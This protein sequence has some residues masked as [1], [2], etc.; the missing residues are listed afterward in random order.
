MGMGTTVRV[1]A[2]QLFVRLGRH[3]RRAGAQH[4]ETGQ[5]AVFALGQLMRDRR[6]KA[7]LVVIGAG[8][9]AARYKLLNALSEEDITYTVYDNVPD[10]PTAADAEAMATAYQSAGCD[11]LIALGDGPLLDAVKA[12]AAG[13]GK[14]GRPVK[15]LAHG[16]V[17]GRRIPPV[18]AA[19]TSSGSGAESLELAAV[20][21]GKGG[22]LFLEGGALMPDVALLDPELM[23]D[24]PREKLA[25]AGMNGLCW[26]VEAYLAASRGD[27][28]TRGLAVE[29]AE[30][31]FASLES[32]WNSGGT[33]RERGDILSA[34]RLAGRAANAAGAGYARA[35]IRAAQ[36][37]CGLPFAGLCGVIL[38]AVLEKYGISARDDLAELAV[39]ADAV[40]EGSR[41][42]RAAALIAR[43]RALAFR[44]GLP[45]EL[46]GVSAQQAARA[47]NMAAAMANPRYISPV[48]WSAEECH[49][50]ILSVCAKPEGGT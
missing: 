25:E 11:S 41:E 37:V 8:E 23:A 38:P 15:A 4:L 46:E 20:A 16:R 27:S 13:C 28:R 40:E 2:A 32:C 35:L 34:S 31:F 50:L 5:G 48:V 44:M 26:A 36:S 29:A 49:D 45:E 17:S 14:R 3:M 12:A 39:M 47:A 30:L 43:I 9:A 1:R 6:L 24:A 18:I 21:D 33:L 10:T 19:P 42:D 7:P 22:Y